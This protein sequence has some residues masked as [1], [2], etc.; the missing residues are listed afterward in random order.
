MLSSIYVSSVESNINNN[1]VLMYLNEQGESLPAGT[2]ITINFTP[3]YL[4]QILEFDFNV[5][6]EN[7]I[8]TVIIDFLNIQGEN[9]LDARK[10]TALNGENLKDFKIVNDIFSSVLINQLKITIFSLDNNNQTSLIKASIKGCYETGM[11]KKDV[12]YR[13]SYCRF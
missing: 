5:L 13:K 12:V 7:K 10:L 11:L 8:D 4:Y 9:V 2:V 1:P 3:G 6:N